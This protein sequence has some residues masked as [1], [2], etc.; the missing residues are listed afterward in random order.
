[1]IR[2]CILGEPASKANSRKIVTFGNRAAS[3][4]GDKAR[5]FERSALQQIP[6][7]ARGSCTAP[8]PPV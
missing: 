2:F 1:M 8:T 5:D 6:P 7:A 4:K 3:I